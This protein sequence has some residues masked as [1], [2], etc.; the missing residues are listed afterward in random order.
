LEKLEEEQHQTIEFDT[1]SKCIKVPDWE[2][3][4]QTHDFNF[5]FESTFPGIN[6]T[7]GELSVSFARAVFASLQGHLRA[8]MWRMSL[9]PKGLFDFY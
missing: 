4:P 5:D 2:H 3:L 9:S 8:V 1:A 6:I 7:D